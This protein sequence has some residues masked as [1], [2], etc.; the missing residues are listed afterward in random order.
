V[1]GLAVTLARRARQYVFPGPSSSFLLRITLLAL[2]I[3]LVW[4]LGIH[5]PGDFIESDMRSYWKQSNSML[6]YPFSREPSAIF[7]PYGTAVLLTA[8]RRVFGAECH[9]A[10]AVVWALLGTSLVPLVHSL[11]ARLSGGP[12]LPRIAAVIACLYYPWISLG[13]Y[14]LSELPFT[15]CVTAAALFSLRLADLGRGRDAFGFGTAVAFGAMFRPQIIAAI[16]L[17]FA[18]W[19]VRRRVWRGL[20]VANWMR[21]AVPIVILVGLSVA[22]YHYHTGR[23][24]FVSGN[25]PLNYAFGR[26]HA[27]TIEAR[28]PNYFASFGPPPMGFLDWRQKHHPDSFIRLD[29]A[30]KTKLAVQGTMW[31]PEPFAELARKCVE[32]T[33]FVRQIR[34]AIVHVVMLWGFNN[35][36][37]DSGKDPYRHVMFAAVTLHNAFLLPPFLVMLVASFRR[38]FVRHALLAVHLVA[39]VFVSMIYF[40]D[41]RYRVPYDGLVIALSL[42]GWRRIFGWVASGAWRSLK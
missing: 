17:L 9:S 33:G 38:R 28:T 34:Y 12:S 14:Y 31:T 37:P 30:L 4:N 8:V 16:P 19:M 41:V 21:F 18:V 40:G 5:P 1:N 22:R 23:L 32:T 27:L 13:G 7:F 42:E 6:N 2:V 25:S 36:W 10:L 15:V 11:S 35:V 39:L 24:G 26:C 20:R 29:P 3:R